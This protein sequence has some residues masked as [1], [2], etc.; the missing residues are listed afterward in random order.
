MNWILVELEFATRANAERGRLA[1]I[2]PD[3]I[4]GN[5]VVP[6]E[7]TVRPPLLRRRY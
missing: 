1:K 7:D 4:E 3:T 2:D 6:R 5:V